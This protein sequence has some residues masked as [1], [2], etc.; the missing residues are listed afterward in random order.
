MDPTLGELDQHRVRLPAVLEVGARGR[1][2]ARGVD[3]D[4]QLIRQW[5]AEGAVDDS[6]ANATSSVD[7]EHPPVYTR[8]PPEIIEDAQTGGP[9]AG[10]LTPRVDRLERD[11]L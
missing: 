4:V 10:A 2:L 1:E 7:A 11:R 8:P 6:P 3:R 5:I 9:D